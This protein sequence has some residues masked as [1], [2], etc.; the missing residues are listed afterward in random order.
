MWW[1]VEARRRLVGGCRTLC[2]VIWRLSEEETRQ[3][4]WQ[5]RLEGCQMLQRLV[6]GV[7]T[8]GMK[9]ATLQ[10]LLW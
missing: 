6:C 2:C 8:A 1:L 7:S 3:M 9:L 10:R 4:V 5:Q